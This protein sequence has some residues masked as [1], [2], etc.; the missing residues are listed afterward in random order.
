M[1]C[2]LLWNIP[3][4]VDHQGDVSVIIHVSNH[5]LHQFNRMTCESRT[6]RRGVRSWIRNMTD[7]YESKRKTF[8]ITILSNPRQSR[9]SGLI[10]FKMVADRQSPLQFNKEVYCWRLLHPMIVERIQLEYMVASLSTLGGAYSAMGDF[11]NEHSVKAAIVSRQQYM[12]AIKMNDPILKSRSK[13]YYAHSLMQR[14][15]LKSGAK[16]IREEYLF[17]RRMILEED[18]EE[19]ELVVTCCLA[20][21]NRYK[22][23]LT[24]RRN[25]K[26]AKVIT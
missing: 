13:I 8:P 17:A 26:E 5:T 2:L 18:K 20:A 16:L 25:E 21:W 1:C 22:Y 15:R 6:F 7:N 11:Y 14:G 12:V 19:F 10:R 4:K 24:L 9:S 23:L 3:P